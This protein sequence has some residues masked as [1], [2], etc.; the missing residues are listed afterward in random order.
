ML[1]ESRPGSPAIRSLGAAF[2]LPVLCLLGWGCNRPALPPDPPPAPPAVEVGGK[3]GCRL[4]VVLVFDQMRADYL[5][6]WQALW[7]EG[8]FRR[9][10]EEGAWF[11]NCHYPFAATATGPGHATLATGRSPESHG[12]IDNYWHDRQTGSNVYC[13][14]GTRP[15]QAIP[16]WAAGDGPSTPERLLGATVGDA[17][18]EASGGK[19]RVVSLAMK[20]RSAVLLG[21]HKPHACYW[22]DLWTGRFMTSSYY[23]DRPHPWV[24]EFDRGKP[25]DRWF[26]KDWTRFRPELDY[27]AH[28]SPDDT[29]GE[30]TGWIQGRVFPHPM[31]GGLAQLGTEPYA[32]RDYYGAVF[33]SP[34]GNEL[35]LE[36]AR[37]AVDAE[38]LGGGAGADLLWLGFPPSMP[39]VIVGGRIPRKCSTACCGRTGSL[40]TCSLIWTP[41]W[42][43]VNTSWC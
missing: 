6:R 32:N 40:P 37:A 18:R 2:L 19:S 26:G 12:I 13:V 33:T 29:S 25:S 36:L 16:A 11:K 8:G 28:S 7:G 10:Q 42:V 41:G 3:G 34:F 14:A 20:D 22:F 27:V 21:G 39:S 43:A 35:L 31:T 24:V 4:A 1:T 23:R 15:Y 38:K 30:A 5:E 9:L 17:L